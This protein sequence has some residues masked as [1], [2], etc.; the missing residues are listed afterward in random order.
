MASTYFHIL[1]LKI[2]PQPLAYFQIP[3]LILLTLIKF[4]VMAGTCNNCF[5]DKLTLG[6][7]GETDF[8][9]PEDLIERPWPLP[10]YI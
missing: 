10:M 5:K 6:L 9:Q 3:V 8:V 1:H 4:L 2:L 7:I